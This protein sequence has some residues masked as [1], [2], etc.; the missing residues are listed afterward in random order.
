MPDGFRVRTYFLS[1]ARKYAEVGARYGT[2]PPVRTA[3]GLLDV[4]LRERADDGAAL[5]LRA[6][7]QAAIGDEQDALDASVELARLSLG[8]ARRAAEQA[9]GPG[10]PRGGAGAAA[11]TTPTTA[12]TARAARGHASAQRAPPAPPWQSHTPHAPTSLPRLSG[13]SGLAPVRSLSDSSPLPSTPACARG[14]DG[15]QPSPRDSAQ[16]PGGGLET[17]P[18]SAGRGVLGRRS[19]PGSS[20][21]KASL[22]GS[23]PRPPVGSAARAPSA[24]RAAG[25]G[26]GAPELA[27][28]RPNPRAAQAANS[29][30]SRQQLQQ[31]IRQWRRQL[32]RAQAAGARF[33]DR[34]GP[35]SE[36]A[37]RYL[38]AEAEER[39][40]AQ[41]AASPLHGAA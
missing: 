37:F 6:Q 12:H 23:A 1:F 33:A 30:A 20:S 15:A 18:P 26:Q 35:E 17:P 19:G 40:R 7:L 16:Q 38:E 24:H 32:V 28:G 21:K 36:W 11:A 4:L 13:L 41:A 8:G 9:A 2:A 31:E 34:S 5:Q 39:Q 10:T 29:V 14:A 3:L 25:A 22:P 27:Q